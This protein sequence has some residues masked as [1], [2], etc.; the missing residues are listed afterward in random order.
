MMTAPTSANPAGTPVRGRGAGRVSAGELSFRTG[1]SLPVTVT[2]W[3]EAAL[4]VTQGR[5]IGK[6]F[7]VLPWQRRMTRRLLAAKTATLSLTMGRGNGKTTWVAALG[8]AALVGPLARQRGEVVI[9]AGSHRQAGI[10]FGHVSAFLADVFADRKRWA[11]R[12][13]VGNRECEDRET[14]A[15]LVAIS[16]DPKRAHGLAPSL[17]IADEPAQWPGADGG[18]A[19]WDALRTA[20]GKQPGAKILALGTRAASPD[21]WFSR[22]TDEDAPRSHVQ[23][24]YAA[25]PDCDV[26]D[27]AAWLAANPSYRAFAEL[28][29]ALRTE[30]EEA[31]FDVGAAARFRALRLNGGSAVEGHGQLIPWTDWRDCESADPPGRTG[32]YSLGIDLGGSAAM[33]AAAGF[34]PETG[35]VEARAA[36]PSVPNL[37]HRGRADGVR[38]L[39]AKMQ[40]RGELRT[41]SGRLVPVGRFL[42]DV[43]GEWGRPA[44]IVAD[45]WRAGELQQALAD[46]G[47]RVPLAFRG[48][49]FRDGGE[50]VRR[51]RRAVAGRLIHAPESLIIRAAL[52]E[53][54][55][56]TDPA[57]NSKLAVRG[58]GGRRSRA[59]DDVA[60]ALILAVAEGDR[61][62]A[63]PR[64]GFRYR[65]LVA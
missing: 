65:G 41:Y 27:E 40:R 15:R 49:G 37:A 9:V 3:I 10:A 56:V 57:G 18:A 51:F 26:E 24:T 32:P 38:D 31:R 43:F 12:N 63:A 22:L 17:V 13:G 7:R 35:R 1:R 5:G 33:S 61:R 52:R 59:R 4:T 60:A 36:F 39:Y 14:G 28:R 47:L 6:P 42:A 19:M 25:D 48:Q 11:V 55:T 64:A 30:A 46:S 34:W 23:L 62:G 50:D 20:V 53:A 54:R 44:V 8:A 58:E 2:R 16:S 21:H 29:K 45:R